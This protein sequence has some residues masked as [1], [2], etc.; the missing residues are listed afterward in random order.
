MKKINFFVAILVCI[1]GTL[2][3][4]LENVNDGLFNNTYS[5]LSELLFERVEA[6]KSLI[7]FVPCTT[8]QTP[9]NETFDSNSNTLACW[10]IKDENNDG[11]GMMNI[12]QSSDFEFYQGDQAM[13]FMGM[14]NNDDWLIS[15][16]I[17]LDATKKYR[18]S[19]YY[20]TNSSYASD[21]D[22]R[23]SSKTN[24]P[25]DFTTLL[26]SYVNSG[27]N[28]WKKETL[29][30]SGTG[31]I[32]YVGFHASTIGTMMLN[33][34]SFAIEEV[35]GCEEPLDLNVR[36]ITRN[37]ADIAWDALVGQSEWEYIVQA[38]G[39][40]MPTVS[41]IKTWTKSNTVTT[42]F[43]LVSLQPNTIY[44]LYVRSSC[45]L[46]GSSV[47][48]GPL[49]FTT[50]CDIAVL[51]YVEGF[52]SDSTTLNCWTI[53]DENSDG[54]V[55]PYVTINMWNQSFNDFQE[56]DASM[57]FYSY[58][59]TESIVH[60]DW[61]ISPT[62]KL[63]GGTYMLRYFYKADNFLDNTMGV[64]LSSNGLDPSDFTTTLVSTKTYKN[65]NFK[66]EIVYI[67]G[68]T[69]DVNIGWHAS[70]KGST[71]LTI[72]HVRMDKVD[73]VPPSNLEAN[74]IKENEFT[75]SWVDSFAQKWEYVVQVA[76]M[77]NV[78]SNGTVSTSTTVIV[79]KDVT[80]SPI[81]SSMEYEF[82][83]RAICDS[84][85][86]TWSGPYTVLTACASF[87]LPFSEGFNI[88]SA[89][90]TNSKNCWR[91][92][93]VQADA[94]AQ[95]G[96]NIWHLDGG[97]PQE[98]DSAAYFRG[99]GNINHDD[100]IISPGLNLKGKSYEITYYYKTGGDGSAP[101]DFEVLLSKDGISIAD[102]STIIQPKATHNTYNKYVKKKIYLKDITGTVN[103]AWRIHTKDS[104][105]SVF[106]LDNV[107]VKEI[108]CIPPG[109][110]AVVSDVTENSAK[111]KWDDVFNS[112]WEYYVTDWNT[113]Q[114]SGIASVKKEVT[115]TK[116]N[117]GNNLLPDT[118][119]HVYIRTK[120]GTSNYSEW[121][122]P[123]IFRTQCTTY[124]VPFSEGFN[125]SSTSLGCWR[126]IDVDNDGVRWLMPPR[127]M[128]FFGTAKYD[129]YE[130]DQVATFF[131]VDK[132]HDD[133]F[134][135]PTI[136]LEG[137]KYAISF[138]YKTATANQVGGMK[139]MEN[140]EFE[141][142]LSTSG[143]DRDDFKT[144]L[145]P[146]KVYR[147]YNYVKK[148]VFVD[149]ITANINLAWHVKS[150]GKTILLLDDVRIEEVAC[151]PPSDPVLVKDI[152]SKTAKLEW[153]T[154]ANGWE[155]YVQPARGSIPTKPGNK[156]LTK[157]V[158]IDKETN[159]AAL[160]PNTSYDVY[161]RSN[162]DATT[163]SIWLGPY[164]FTTLCN[165]FQAPFW[166]GFNS[167][168]WVNKSESLACWTIIDS[169]NDTKTW[170]P[171]VYNAYE[172]DQAMYFNVSDFTNVVVHDDWLISPTLE[173]ISG[174]YILKYH[175]K[176]DSSY[177]N[178]FE[179][180][181]S[182][183]GL[184]PK[185]FTTS[186][187]SKKRYKN[188]K[189]IEEIVYIKGVQG[190]VNLAW[191]VTGKGSSTLLV[192][193][194]IVEKASVCPTPFNVQSKNATAN[195]FEVT[196]Q[197]SGVVAAWTVYVVEKGKQPSSS[198][199]I[200][201]TV[202]GN[203][204]CIVSGL[205]SSTT[206][207][208]YVK[209][210]C[211]V[212]DE[213]T[214]SSPHRS[215]THQNGINDCIETQEVPV[216]KSS[217]CLES[218]SGTFLGSRLSNIPLPSCWVFTTTTGAD[219]WYS[220][221][222]SATTQM[223]AI[224]DI[225]S[226][227]S[228]ITY[229]IEIAVYDIPCRSITSNTQVL[230]ASVQTGFYPYT[231]LDDL[232]IGKEYLLRLGVP[233]KNSDVIFNICIS[234]PDTALTIDEPKN[235]Q[236]IENMANEVLLK[237]DCDLVSNPKFQFGL[238]NKINAIASFTKG[239]SAFALTDGVVLA[240]HAIDNAKGPKSLMN[241]NRTKVTASIGDVDLNAI[242]TSLGSVRS[243]RTSYSSVYTFDFVSVEDNIQFDY[244]FASD[245][246]SSSCSLQC[247]DAGAVMAI[248]MEDL[249]TGQKQ[250]VALL[251]GT[252]TPVSTSTI[253]KAGNFE[254]SCESVNPQ[255]F[256]K[257]Y[258][259]DVDNPFAAPINYVGLT[260][261]M[262]T[263]PFTTI[264]GRKYRVKM[265]IMDQC[266]DHNH[267]SAMFVASQVFSLPKI[268]VNGDRLVSTNTAICAGELHTIESG[269]GYLLD[270][271]ELEVGFQW[272]K[273]GMLIP[274]EQNDALVVKEPGDYTLK[275]LYQDLSCG[276][277]GIFKIEYY[278]ALEKVLNKPKDWF[279]CKYTTIPQVLDLT[280]IK[281]EI[282]GAKD[283]EDYM[284]Q[285]YKSKE[286]LEQNKSEIKDLTAFL[287]APTSPD[288]ITIFIKVLDKNTNC[289]GVFS[290]VIHR[291][292]GVA[293][294]QREDVEVCGEYV[295]PLLE[296]NQAYYLQSGAQGAKISVNDVL[297]IPGK[298]VV[299][300]VQQ[301]E[302]DI[303]FEEISYKVEVKQKA[304]A[305]V[306]E[307]VK[308]QC[309]FYVL[310]VLSQNNH[311]FTSKGGSGVE[312]FAGQEIR[313]NQIIYIYAKLDNNSCTDESSFAIIYE[314]C[315]IPKGFSPNNDGFNDRFDLSKHG[316]SSLKIYNRVGSEVYSFV[317]EYT[318]Q[319][320]GKSKENKDLPSGT[321]YYIIQIQHTIKTGWI[322]LNR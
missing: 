71:S 36:N 322:E 187:V 111:I 210:I 198:T 38:K 293:P 265:G 184:D 20:K 104:L 114:S 29:F 216:N 113:P 162:C 82:Y 212:N 200:V 236:E 258:S 307:D 242:A 78:P 13:L 87:N 165:E 7:N 259:Y 175:Y 246:Y 269:L 60:N 1:T 218:T 156:V 77:G 97:T 297:N 96:S 106:H 287:I 224:N 122:G 202:T 112:A 263:I 54:M 76:G 99:Y 154:V 137:K 47:W 252:N 188:D 103:I 301:N 304:K 174:D 93:D 290:V 222:A 21:F 27:T 256:A 219:L 127:D 69:G 115:I 183:S 288:Q 201:Q 51:P 186:L 311:Y 267:G 65:A 245:L 136:K 138:Y 149:N 169:N 70:S 89:A 147:E 190:K 12:W 110:D 223:I 148:I 217:V 286:D 238:D 151:I 172:G 194:V 129:Q 116:D 8:N 295:F 90:D 298:Y 319:W 153:A 6:R 241:L 86:S 33:L 273:D 140:S 180:L 130:G 193:N 207:D 80:G 142:L 178:E 300:V 75:M 34:D 32:V 62:F 173:L 196:W 49:E 230:C 135:S 225:Y 231:I 79:D 315:P 123:I 56:G 239:Q 294:K 24:S 181:L 25:A 119:Y 285:F 195:G 118:E 168:Y 277:E 117:K 85:M 107:K 250:N 305:D 11:S 108:S 92:I 316:V 22:V 57:L 109:E 64:F 133:W 261:P 39:L 205:K 255:Y 132:E 253:R 317:G 279:V 100:W 134:I 199:A 98:G 145:L 313:K 206:Y 270:L 318:N 321:Y 50:A 204:V 227:N 232:I 23:L 283:S 209:A 58:D 72:D 5:A 303:C 141:L 102:F 221:T 120:C 4:A 68:I 53:R 276:A 189:Y 170:G 55:T 284:W 105:E 10:T 260:V 124:S 9:F 235:T 125:T 163:A 257:N 185:S 314:E 275:V 278:D 292:N 31:G 19:Y 226:K 296:S 44:E 237:S 243:P 179:V 306:L 101:I 299:Y 2:V 150:N 254:M 158:L 167:E 160:L 43:K 191:H 271:N 192:D 213:S 249:V 28:G 289:S 35:M 139:E 17:A 320:D 161:V 157:A 14:E 264:P 95:Y 228:H 272:Y 166:E 42:D 211:S 41:G 66:E 308:M 83:V 18:I 280:S 15:P 164:R 266:T 234:S 88:V 215:S 52:N 248:I 26:T 220:F 48:S 177:E 152:T 144:V 128:N 274:N 59:D 208:V 229:P 143:I 74:R 3:Y 46:G 84:S 203:P 67:T 251:A 268:N 197:Q 309:A 91:I 291:T 244:L 61:L 126:N 131:G 282:A 16:Q 176:A 262:K 30:L 146:S 45:S 94:E 240:T 81:L 233:Y 310:P 121:I 73:C 312:L 281:A 171:Y 182:T 302:G 155:Y 40:G 63:D 159:G 214:L 37:S 247:G